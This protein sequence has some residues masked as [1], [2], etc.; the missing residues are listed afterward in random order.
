MS[1]VEIQSELI[2]QIISALHSDDAKDRG[3]AISV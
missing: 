2:K 1:K 3:K